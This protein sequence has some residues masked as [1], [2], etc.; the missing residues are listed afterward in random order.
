V[1]RTVIEEQKRAG[2]ER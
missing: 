1:K 2:W